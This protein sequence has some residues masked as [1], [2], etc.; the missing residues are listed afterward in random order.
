MCVCLSYGRAEYFSNIK[1]IYKMYSSISIKA[2]NSSVS[3]ACI[4]L[5]E[6]VIIVNIFVEKI[7]AWHMKKNNIDFAY[8]Y[9]RLQL[10]PN[11]FLIWKVLLCSL[12][13]NMHIDIIDDSTVSFDNGLERKHIRNL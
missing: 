13:Y 2:N 7:P 9:Y 6:S 12:F 4:I 1:K 3:C 8:I 5:C 11:G 10:W